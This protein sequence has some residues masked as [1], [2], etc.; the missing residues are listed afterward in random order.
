[1]TRLRLSLLRTQN[2]LLSLD[3]PLRNIDDSIAKSGG[4]FFEG[5]ALRFT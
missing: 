5:F 1:M 2:R 3:I 4:D